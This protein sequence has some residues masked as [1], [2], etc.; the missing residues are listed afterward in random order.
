LIKIEEDIIE[1]IKKDFSYDAKVVID[2]FLSTM[3]EHKSIEHPRIIRSI[4]YLSQGD[5]FEL[6]HYLKMA[7]SDWRDVIYFAEYETP[8][9][10][11]V[12]KRVRDFNNQFEQKDI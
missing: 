11:T 9:N 12:K 8:S 1:K 4:I 7:V 10:G 6:K 3:K 5:L 2:L